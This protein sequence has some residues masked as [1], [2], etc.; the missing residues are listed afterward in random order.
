MITVTIIGGIDIHVLALGNSWPTSTWQPWNYSLC[1]K[2][3]GRAFR[4]F[5]ASFAFWTRENWGERKI[6][7]PPPPH[8][9]H[10][11]CAHPNFPSAKNRK[12]H[13][14]GGKWTQS[15]EQ[16][17]FSPR[18]DW[19]RDFRHLASGLLRASIISSEMSSEIPKRAPFLKL[20]N[21]RTSLFCCFEK[22]LLSTWKKKQTVKKYLSGQTTRS[23]LNLGDIYFKNCLWRVAEHK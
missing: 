1:S 20:F 2:R 4:R 21:V 23:L 3:F 19:G 8:S 17:P 14:T 16:V 13:R 10:Q 18:K 9:F 22:R 5:E 15:R 7:S 6:T 11:C 12:M